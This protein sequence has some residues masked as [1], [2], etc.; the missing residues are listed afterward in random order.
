MRAPQQVDDAALVVVRVTRLAQ[1][2]VQAGGHV[3]EGM[4]RGQFARQPQRV[5][6]I[7]ETQRGSEIHRARVISC[8][9]A[10]HV[11][12]YLRTGRLPAADGVTYGVVMAT[13]PTVIRLMRARDAGEHLALVILVTDAHTIS[14]DSVYVTEVTTSIEPPASQVNFLAREVR[15]S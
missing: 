5:F 9:E 2:P 1:A 8:D 11:A 10:P 14:L 7:L 3:A 15:F 4:R 13:S 6:D 12:H